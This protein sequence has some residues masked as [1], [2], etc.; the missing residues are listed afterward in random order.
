[1]QFSLSHS[2]SAGL[3]LAGGNLQPCHSRQENPANSH[4]LV[5]FFIFKDEI[6]ATKPS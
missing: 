5:Y 3:I 1:M 4:I 2:L 6:S